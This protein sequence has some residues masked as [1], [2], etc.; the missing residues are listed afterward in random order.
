[1]D[2]SFFMN[3]HRLVIEKQRQDRLQALKKRSVL[4][5]GAFA[6]FKSRLRL[7]NVLTRETN[8]YFRLD[9]TPLITYYDSKQLISLVQ[10]DGYR[11]KLSERETFWVRHHRQ[12]VREMRSETQ[13]FIIYKE[14]DPTRASRRDDE[15][16][17]AYERKMGINESSDDDEW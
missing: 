4:T 6:R 8:T 9:Y 5:M 7:I 2:A 14:K 17:R 16:N 13:T 15:R 12:D 10:D 1:M 3:V 11:L